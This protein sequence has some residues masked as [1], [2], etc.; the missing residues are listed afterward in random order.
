MKLKKVLC[1][2]LVCLVLCGCGSP[3][4]AGNMENA[5]DALKWE[6][7][8]TAFREADDFLARM[9]ENQDAKLV[10]ESAAWGKFHSQEV[11]MKLS[12]GTF[13][14]LDYGFRVDDLPR[15]KKS[16]IQITGYWVGMDYDRGTV[17]R[18]EISYLYLRSVIIYWIDDEGAEQTYEI[19]T[20]GDI[21]RKDLAGAV[22]ELP[23]DVERMDP[24]SHEQLAALAEKLIAPSLQEVLKNVEKQTGL[25][26][27]HL[28]FAAWND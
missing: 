25:T 5:L 3:K 14:Q 9:P 11:T 12:K 4:N 1:L 23:G 22:L 8:D 2:A 16:D 19:Y 24:R 26:P 13:T 17:N 18:Q 7:Y 20:P 10:R 28:G 21:R 27:E 6:D 15:Q